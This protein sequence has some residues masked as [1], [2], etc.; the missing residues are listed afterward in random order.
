[1]TFSAS[2][3]VCYGGSFSIPL[4]IGVV[5]DTHVWDHGRRRLPA[6]VPELFERLGVGLILHAGDINVGSVLRMLERLAPT[7]AVRGNNDDGELQAVLPAII[8]FSVGRFTFALLHGDDGRTARTA[9]RRYVGR[10]DCVVYGHSHIPKIETIEQ[11]I[12]FN[13]GSA[14]DRRWQPHFGVGCIH[15]G[16]TQI[17]P[18]LILFDDPSHLAHIGRRRSLR[19]VP[20]AITRETR[21]CH[22]LGTG[23]KLGK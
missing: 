19:S 5:A 18:D 20:T 3:E 4:V 9:A 22:G 8:E 21:A 1:M 2:G 7:F 16:E 14:T 13:P 23:R 15:V 17:V 6:E 12:L 10:A 11:T